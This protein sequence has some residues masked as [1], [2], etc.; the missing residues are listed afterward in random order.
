VAVLQNSSNQAQPVT[1]APE[2]AF[3]NN[4]RMLLVGTGRLMDVTDWGNS[5]VQTFYAITDGTTL[6]NARSNLAQQVYTR[7]GDVLTTTAVNWGTQRGW[8]MD[9]PAGEHA[10]TRPS[11]VYGGVAWVTNMAGANDCSASSYLYVLDVASGAR[12]TNNSTV[13]VQLWDKA[14][15]TGVNAVVTSNGDVRGIVRSYDGD[16][17]NPTLANQ[18]PIPASKNAWREVQR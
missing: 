18:P 3:V 1:A 5:Q 17:K 13:S 15:S 12:S 4:A 7:T 10:N 9:L 6:T 2:L 8:Y 11:I 16:R 14:N